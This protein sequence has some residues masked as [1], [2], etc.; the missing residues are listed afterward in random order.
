LQEP[1]HS[2][3]DF[4]HRPTKTSFDVHRFSLIIVKLLCPSDLLSDRIT[5]KSYA[6]K[7]RIN[8]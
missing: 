2:Q 7:L 8:T 5:R 6:V 3:S 1:L 4:G